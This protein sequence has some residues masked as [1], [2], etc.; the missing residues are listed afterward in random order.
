M[1][2]YAQGIF[3]Q[4]GL[5]I[6]IPEQKIGGKIIAQLRRVFAAENVV[7][8]ILCQT[9]T[10]AQIFFKGFS[11]AAHH[12]VHFDFIAVVQAA[13]RGRLHRCLQEIPFRIQSR[14]AG[15]ILAFHQHFDQIIRNAE[16]LAH[17]GNHADGVQIAHAR[18][19]RIHLTLGSQKYCICIIHRPFH[20]GH[21][22]GAAHLK[23]NNVIR[24]NHQ[25]AQCNGRHAQ[26]IVVYLNGNSFRH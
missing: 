20:S 15:A 24:E 10:Q 17:L 2:G 14:Q 9:R 23:M 26:Y 19:F 22:F 16:H 25:P 18:F 1:P 6:L 4:N 13:H 3:L 11:N 12:S 8:N 5:L 7:H 21:R